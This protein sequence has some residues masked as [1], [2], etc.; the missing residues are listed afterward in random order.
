MQCS[1]LIIISSTAIFLYAQFNV[2]SSE[3]DEILKRMHGEYIVHPEQYFDVKKRN[4]IRVFRINK[5][6]Q[7]KNLSNFY[8]KL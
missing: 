3:K 6:L 5:F 4:S 7:L 1:Y 2:Q 8:I